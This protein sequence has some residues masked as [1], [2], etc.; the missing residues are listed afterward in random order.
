MRPSLLRRAAAAA[1][2]ISLVA[3]P[4]TALANPP[5]EFGPTERPAVTEPSPIAIEP[6]VWEALIDHKVVLTLD[7]GATVPATVLGVTDD[8][9]VC[10]RAEDGLMV[11]IEAEQVAYVHVDA[12]PGNKRLKRPETGQPLIVL[13]SIL[14]AVGGGL[15]VATLATAGGCYVADGS[16]CVYVAMPLAAVGMAGLSLGIPFLASGLS[17]RKRLRAALAAE[18]PRL[19]GFLVPGRSGAMAGFGVRF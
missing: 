9:L 19:S 4:G 2:S 8:V 15:G 14:T 6:S 16:L 10:S 5:T 3:L 7:D 11:V 18:T 13:G 17:K 1:I 12:L